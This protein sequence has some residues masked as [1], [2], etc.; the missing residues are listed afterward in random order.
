MTADT[1]REMQS[2]PR[3]GKSGRGERG[4]ALIEFAL[5]L[6]MLLV[7]T[8][9]AVDFGRAFFVKNVLEQ[10]AREGARLRV[11]KSSA[12]TADVRVRVQDVANACKVTVTGITISAQGDNAVKV[13][14]D[15]QFNWIFPGVF[16]LF[17]AGFTNPMNLHGNAVMR[18]EGSS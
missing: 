1:S 13:K 15:G 8:V 9:A 10:A 7:L 12:D 11:V 5:V 14:V 4:T 3:H 16:N 18:L 6:P 17:G 2:H